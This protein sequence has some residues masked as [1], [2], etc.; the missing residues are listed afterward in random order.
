MFFKI[1]FL[2]IVFFFRPFIF[3]NENPRNEVL[4]GFTLYSDR[5]NSPYM[6]RLIDN[7][8]NIIGE[9]E[10]TYYVA[11][12]PYIL[13]DASVLIPSRHYSIS[14]GGGGMSGRIARFNL[15]Y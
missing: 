11:S 13:A 14:W 2:Y 1:I 5:M 6:T 3:P 8:Y 15:W 9:W 12:T 7:D 10:T 4:E